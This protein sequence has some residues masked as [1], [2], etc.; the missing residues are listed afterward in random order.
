MPS[1]VIATATVR[2]HL[3]FLYLTHPNPTATT[4]AWSLFD[5]TGAAQ[6]MSGDADAAPYDS[7]LEAMKDGW[8]VMQVAQQQPAYPGMEHRTAYLPFEFILERLVEMSD[9]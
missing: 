7:V 2:Q 1:A 9:E 5:G 6:R 8:R 4:I 3:L